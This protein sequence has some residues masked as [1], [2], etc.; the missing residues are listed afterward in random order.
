MDGREYQTTLLDSGLRLMPSFCIPKEEKTMKKQKTSDVKIN[1]HIDKYLI[2]KE[3]QTLTD[4]SGIIAKYIDDKLHYGRALG[5]AEGQS[6]AFAEIKNR[7]L[8]GEFDLLPE[9]E[10][11]GQM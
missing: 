2:T 5:F 4:G 1:F 7:V 6:A 9:E 8:K 10:A 11:N 3:L